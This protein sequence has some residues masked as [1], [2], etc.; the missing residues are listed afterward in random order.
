MGRT[1]KVVTSGLLILALA[2][3]SVPAGMNLVPALLPKDPAAVAITPAAQL[4]PA[5]L[6]SITGVSPLPADAPLPNSA[7][8]AAALDQALSADGVGQFSAYVADASTGKSLY[9]NDGDDPRIPASNLKLLTALAALKS[10]GAGTRMTTSVMPGTTP[11][12]L[13]LRGGG[14]A[15]LATGTSDPSA[16][17]G[18]AGLATLAKETAAA[19]AKAG[20]SGPITLSVDDSLFTGPALNPN[21]ADGDVASGQIAPIYP[22]ALYAARSGPSVMTGPRPEDSAMTVTE[23]FAAALEAAGI[24]VSGQIARAKAPEGAPLAS[25][26]SATVAEQVQYFLVESDNYLAEVMARLVASKQH[27]EASNTG[28]VKAVREVVTGLGLSLDGVA[29]TDNCGLALGNLISAKT[30]SQTISLMLAQS[31]SDVG[32][33]LAGLP[34]AGLSGTLGGRFSGGDSLSVAGL[35]RAKTGTLF[36]VSALTGYVINAQGRVLVFSIIGNGL[37]A[38]PASATPIIDA[39]ATILAKS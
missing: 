12:S 1:S 27:Q 18:H 5:T 16:V 30:L 38:G 25:I 11:N 10:L 31:G 4:P 28:A 14:D 29:T 9:S 19:L 22:L 20:V 37:T 39:A 36:E 2:A 23:A 26:S 8:L 33:A 35:V 6:G 32:Q 13:I 21:W 34:I 3:V 24:P 7:D 15:M 17:M